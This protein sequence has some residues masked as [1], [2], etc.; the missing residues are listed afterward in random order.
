MSQYLSWDP[1]SLLLFPRALLGAASPAERSGLLG[2]QRPVI[3]GNC[4]LSLPSGGFLPV[5]QSDP[6]LTPI[7]ERDPSATLRKTAP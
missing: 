2:E 6:W 3:K 5:F 1:S 4:V 7:L